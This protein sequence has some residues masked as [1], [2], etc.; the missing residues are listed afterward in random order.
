MFGKETLA[1]FCIRM[2]VWAQCLTW[3]NEFGK[4]LAIS[5]QKKKKMIYK[6]PSYSHP[7]GQKGLLFT[8]SCMYLHV[9]SRNR[10][11]VLEN[12]VHSPKEVIQEKKKEFMRSRK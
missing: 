4:V 6:L 2:S 9:Y 7:K 5:C 3:F 1:K 8:Q 11:T 12:C 10:D